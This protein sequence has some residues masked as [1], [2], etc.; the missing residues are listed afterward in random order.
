MA[1]RREEPGAAAGESAAGEL[2]L[3][4]GSRTSG[5]H[6]RK[7]LSLS[8]FSLMPPYMDIGLLVQR[9]WILGSGLGQLSVDIIFEIKIYVLVTAAQSPCNFSWQRRS[10]FR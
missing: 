4:Q 7:C 10:M 8:F 6:G 1:R 3:E 2:E 5:L 9:I